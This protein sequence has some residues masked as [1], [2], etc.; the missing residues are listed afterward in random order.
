MLLTLI[1]LLTTFSP[2]ATL[3]PLVLG[4]QK[5]TNGSAQVFAY[6]RSVAFDLK[7]ESS[8]TEDGVTIRDVNY[9]PY[10]PERGRIKAFLIH[11]AGEGRFA[12]VLFF[13]WLGEHKSDR[14]E[15]LDEAVALAKQGTVSL[16]IQGYFPWTVAPKDGA[17]DRQRVID[18]TIEVRRALDLL[19][20]QP[21]VDRKR[22]G[23]WDTITEP[24][25][26]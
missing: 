10:T 13:H 2:I 1:L 14:T 12:G 4:G 9:A 19:L 8:K 6:D 23:T 22:I 11:P 18:E 5:P 7:E 26:A 16:L 25:M 24:C 20:T 3:V 15:Y 21:G 17:T